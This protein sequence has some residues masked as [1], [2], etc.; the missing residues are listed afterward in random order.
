MQARARA[1][2]D[3]GNENIALSDVTVTVTS[4]SGRSATPGP[5]S[6]SDTVTGTVCHTGIESG[7]FQVRDRLCRV[8]AT[9]DTHCSPAASESDFPSPAPSPGPI[10]GGSGLQVS[11]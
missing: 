3:A 8:A 7:L 10:T 5:G 11:R 4:T 6:E 2:M 1:C 9:P